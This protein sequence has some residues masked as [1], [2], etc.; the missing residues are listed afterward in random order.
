MR[1]LVYEA[2][3]V[4]GISTGTQL[5]ARDGCAT[6]EQGVTYYFLRSRAHA[7]TPEEPPDTGWVLLIEYRIQPPRAVTYKSAK[8]PKRIITPE[9]STHLVAISRKDFETG[10]HSGG[11]SRCAIQ[12]KM[13]PWLAELE[14]LNLA[15]VDAEREKAKKSHTDRIDEKLEAIQALVMEYER[16]L[17]S[18]DPD[19]L[20]NCHA[21]SLK[22]NETRLRLWFYTYLIFGRNRFA[23]HYP[24]QKPGRWSR[25]THVSSVKRGRPPKKGKGH[26][27]NTSDEMEKMIDTGYRREC[28]L[29]VLMSD[30][31]VRTL[32]KDF[33]CRTRE[34][35]RGRRTQLEVWHPQGKPFPQKGAFVS[36]VNKLIGAEEVQKTLLGRVI[37]RSK[38]LPT[39]GPFTAKTWNLMQRVERDAYAAREL[40][41][42]LIEGS[43][44]PPLYVTRKRDTASGILSGIGFS[45]GGERASAYRMANFCEAINKVRF[46]R[47]WGIEITPDRWPSIGVAPADIQDRGAGATPGAASR[48]GEFRPIVSELAASHSG[49]GKAVIESSNPKTL[50]NDEAPSFIQS[51]LRTFELVR[52]E[53][54]ELIKFNDSSGVGDRTPPDLADQIKR[55]GPNGLYEM[56]DSLGRNDG[57]QMSFEDA[58]RTYLDKVDAKLTSDG[59]IL[60]GQVY[61]STTFDASNARSSVSGNE[62]LPVQIYLL[63][64]CIRHIWIDWK[65]QLIELDLQFPVPVGKDV[66]YMSLEELKQF[67]SF[68]K[69]RD[70]D[71]KEHRVAVTL[72]THEEF[73]S[74]IGKE[75]NS[76]SRVRGRAK[77]GTR[78]AKQE[79]A[80]VKNATRGR[81]A[82]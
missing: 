48:K 14:G 27:Y 43:P 10:L 46:C 60:C 17:D 63:E 49:Q 33:G 42:G 25:R 54:F 56:L 38:K 67:E 66:L 34:V 64:A 3:A 21:R 41:R 28:G 16:I 31:Y 36:C 47:L 55:P 2:L 78:T 71:D 18:D 35:K 20:I 80:E 57:L 65:G 53:I 4:A 13:P 59:V 29:G 6:L 72:K 32:R 58:V 5:E 15:I 45:Q 11:I 12:S 75:W 37:T 44:L 50:S 62:G 39:R 61:K 77:R 79:A 19:Y 51:N 70:F 1:P 8:R 68:C 82:E 74:T 69:E 22:K 23:L 30:I 73:R 76:E 9:P 40:A 26:G 52:R 81:K 24:I 7:K